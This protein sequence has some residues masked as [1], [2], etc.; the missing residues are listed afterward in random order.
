MIKEREEEYRAKEEET[1][2]LRAARLRGHP[3]RDRMTMR[4]ERANH[5]RGI[6]N[7]PIRF[8]DR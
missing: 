7:G 6:E 3:V 4:T 8:N 2:S 1:V 5:P